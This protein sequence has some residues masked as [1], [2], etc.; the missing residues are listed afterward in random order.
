M[1]KGRFYKVWYSS[2]EKIRKLKN[3]MKGFM[4]T[5][6]KNLNRLKG[7]MGLSIKI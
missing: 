4:G 7:V 6:T 5:W 1:L 3:D 2:I